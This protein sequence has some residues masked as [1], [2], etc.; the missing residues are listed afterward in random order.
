MILHI[1]ARELRS[2]FFSPLAWI[3]LGVIQI[4]LAWKFLGFI[5]IF[6]S[7]QAEL[8]KIKNAPGVTDLIVAPFFEFSKIILLIITPLITMGLL[9]AEKQNG[10]IKLLLSSPV[11]MTQIVLGKYLGSLVFFIIIILV[12]S[13]MPLFLLSATDL[14]M[15][16]FAAGLLALLLNVAAFV[17]LGLYMSCISKQPMQAAAGTFGLLILFWIINNASRATTE[18][19][20][21]FNYLSMTHHS[22]QMLRG[23]VYLSDI[24]YFVL[25]SLTFILLSIRSLDAQRMQA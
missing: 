17:A 14:D 13:L 8:I 3:I 11:S 22:I 12:I 21:F 25:F 24:S 23:L 18:G 4:L 20:N 19:D 5:D 6:F 1:A 7:L 15:G 9:S 10:S 2:L 16:K